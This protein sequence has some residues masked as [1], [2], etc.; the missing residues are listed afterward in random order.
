[1]I[2]AVRYL[3]GCLAVLS[4]DFHRDGLKMAAMLI[5]HTIEVGTGG[6]QIDD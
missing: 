5:R 1:M 3:G 2:D 6:M 4:H